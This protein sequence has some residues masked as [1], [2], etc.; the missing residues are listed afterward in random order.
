MTSK[1]AIKWIPRE[2]MDEMICIKTNYK[3]EKDS[4]AFK[5]LAQ[6]SKIGREIRN[7]LNA[8]GI[9]INLNRKKR[10]GFF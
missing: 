7:N 2:V 9:D 3:I 5:M 8:F 10:G 4:K 6:D 1:G